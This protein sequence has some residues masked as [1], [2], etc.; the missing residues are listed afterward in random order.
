[1]PSFT[2]CVLAVLQFRASS[3]ALLDVALAVVGQAIGRENGDSV[4]VVLL[5]SSR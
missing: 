4:L 5:A 1:M 3:L 2:S